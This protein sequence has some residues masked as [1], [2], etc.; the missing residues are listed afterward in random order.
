LN[1]EKVEKIANAVLYEGYILYPYRPSS[2]KNRK[3]F[4][5]GVLAPP[6]YGL[7]PSEM[8]TECLVSGKA[9]TLLAV[10]VR[11]LQVMEGDDTGS[12]QQAVEREAAVADC[13]LEDLVCQSAVAEFEFT[14]ELQGLVNVSARD[15]G[16]GLFQ[17]TALVS[18]Q[19][20]MQGL[21]PRERDEIL[22]FSLISTHT[23][24]TVK[25]GEF[26]SLLDP[27]D[28]FKE[29]AAR[30]RNMGTWPVLAGETS[31]RDVM[32]SS[33]IILY[34]HPQIAAESPGDLFDGT[35]I[36]E[37]LTL[38]ILTMTDE[39]KQEMRNADERGRQILERTEKLSEE[40]LKK[41]HGALRGLRPPD[42]DRS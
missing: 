35:E 12:W 27:P 1:L 38:R 4:N 21:E 15:W 3:R 41:L 39:E 2:V 29:A 19:S 14:E 33:P 28:A 6:E 23:I 30:C 13:R 16:N 17:V 18:N 34:D 40:H 10:K 20:N 9:Q 36:D 11:F 7:E 8:R 22:P 5:F 42:G 25:D 24:L 32:L 26:I 37:I 31:E